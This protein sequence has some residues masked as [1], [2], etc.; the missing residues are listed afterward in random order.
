MTKTL[1]LCDC[2]GS[3]SLD[4]SSLSSATGLPCSKVH[5]DLCGAQSA[6]A[7]KAMQ[8]GDTLIACTQ[9]RSFFETLAEELEVPTPSFV[10]LRDRAGWSDDTS[11]KHPKMSALAS[12]ALFAI[13][14]TKTRDVTS[15]GLCLI[16]SPRG[17]T[18]ADV[19]DSIH[20]VARD[21]SETLNVT[22]LQDSAAEVPTDRRYDTVAGKLNT[23]RGSFG[24]FEVKIESFQSL[25]Q[26]GRGA[27]KWKPSQGMALSSCDI[28]ID[29][30]GQIPLFP[31]PEKRDGYL[32]ADIRHLPAVSKVVL[33]ASQLVGIFEKTLFVKLE[34]SLCAHSRAEQSA[35]SNCL[36]A[37]PTGAITSAGDSVAI[38][39]MICAGCGACASLCPSGAITYEAPTFQSVFNRLYKISEVYSAAGGQAPRLLVHDSEYG[40]EMI[41]LAARYGQGLPADVIPFESA[42]L[43]SFGHAEILSALAS[44]FVA[45]DILP[46]PNSDL[47]TLEKELNLARA[48]IPE[49]GNPPPRLLTATE[50]DALCDALYRDQK[51]PSAT[52][53]ILPL[54]NRRQ[55]TRLAAQS[56]HQS[57]DVIA[58]PQDAPY[59]AVALQTDAC[60]LCLSCVSL[61]PSGAL[62]DN[63]DMPQLR[64]QEDACLQCGLCTN[65]CPE[66]AIELVPRLNLS[67]EAMDQVVLHEEAPCS[68]IECGALFGVQSTVDKIMEK[69]AG[70]H[71]MFATSEAAKLI[72]MCDNCRVNA[73]FHSENSPFSGKE[74]PAPRMSED[75]FSKRKD[76]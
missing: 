50:P 22:V 68:C 56:F 37:C 20:Q 8:V 40:I 32:R 19:I 31:A 43:A 73:Q 46:S 42:A 51:S 13:P 64:F 76:H 59:G 44:G 60:T 14:A 58:L 69:L 33:E 67:D 70:N 63:P 23:A 57:N 66:N 41:Q 7:A 53:P 9:E 52:P 38:D 12:D 45:V 55:V 2:L 65:I 16:V 28:I 61:C 35:C 24:D 54:G 71:P 1:I 26:G 47:E 30:S 75:Y 6:V 21:L 29:L 72:Q 49:S 3:Q 5:T 36:N 48:L 25:T 15:E 34:E 4:P 62:A 11:S 17:E 74:R 39:P 10:D 27:P 18:S